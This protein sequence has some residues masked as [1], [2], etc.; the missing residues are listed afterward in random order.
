MHPRTFLILTKLVFFFNVLAS[1]T[2]AFKG[3]KCH[4]GKHSILRL[5]VMLGANADGSEKLCPLVIGKSKRP[6]CFKNVKTLHTSYDANQK[7]WMTSELFERQM[8][9]LDS[10]VGAQNRKIFS[11]LIAVLHIHRTCI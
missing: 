2:L 8:H 5:T 1:K 4:G 6:R 11:L 10:K 3:E 7:A 9:A